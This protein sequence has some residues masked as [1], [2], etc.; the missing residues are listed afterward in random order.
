MD[1][2][3]K[4]GRNDDVNI[5]FLNLDRLSSEVHGKLTPQLS[6][7]KTAVEKYVSQ[8]TNSPSIGYGFFYSTPILRVGKIRVVIFTTKHQYKGKK[9]ETQ[10]GPTKLESPVLFQR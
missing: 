6:G 3:P 5:V 9:E 8:I 4:S 10:I 7:N 1:E 2:R